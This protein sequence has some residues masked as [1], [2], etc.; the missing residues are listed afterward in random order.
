MMKQCNLHIPKQIS[1]KEKETKMY[2]I[3]VIYTQDFIMIL[4]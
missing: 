3:F 1:I 2:N 4:S